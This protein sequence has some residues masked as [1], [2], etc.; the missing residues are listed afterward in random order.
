MRRRHAP[1]DVY[2]STGFNPCRGARYTPM[3]ELRTGQQ[4]LP[5]LHERATD[6]LTPA[7]ARLRFQLPQ[8][9]MRLHLTI[10]STVLV[11]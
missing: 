1:D 4:G 10:R 9:T 2:R 3:W 5:S 11:S 8:E 6:A 7:T